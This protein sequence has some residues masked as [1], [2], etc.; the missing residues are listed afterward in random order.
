MGN[1][2][3]NNEDNLYLNGVYLTPETRDISASFVSEYNNETLV[4][5]VFDGM[6]GEALGEEASLIAATAVHEIRHRPGF[7]ENPV[8]HICAAI[9]IANDRI[10][11]KMR[12]TG[13]RRIG[14]TF[15]AVTVKNDMATVYNVG[16]SRVYLYR[17][18]TLTQI[19]VDDTNGQRLLNMGVITPE[20]LEEHPDRHKLTQHLGIY[21]NEMTIEP[22]ISAPIPLKAGDKL[23]ICSDGLT[24][25]VKAT[26]IADVL[27]VS[28]GAVDTT[29]TLVTQAL[30]NGGR[31]NVT[32]MV[33]TALTDPAGATAK[34]AVSSAAVNY[35]PNRSEKRKMTALY[36]VIGLLVA[37]VAVLA[38]MLIMG[39]NDG[40]EVTTEKDEAEALQE[41][42]ADDT[43]A[44]VTDVAASVTD[45]ESEPAD[46]SEPEGEASPEEETAVEPEEEVT[47]GT[48]ESD[49][50]VS[51]GENTEVAETES[52]EAVEP[53][54]ED[55]AET[56]APDEPEIGTF[57][58]LIDIFVTPVEDRIDLYFFDSA[59]FLDTVNNE[60]N[61]DQLRTDPA[62]QLFEPYF[63]LLP[64]ADIILTDDG[65]GECVKVE[66]S[67]G[68]Y[69]IDTSDIEVGSFKKLCM[70][71]VLDNGF[72]QP[73]DV[74]L[75][76]NAD[77]EITVGT[78]NDASAKE[79]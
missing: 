12:E 28:A 4:Y 66:K 14:T 26:M 20:Q 15:A 68:G 2:R 27:S 48:A 69:Y 49:L 7:D 70:S 25:M 56:V 1:I 78:G 43:T 8:E 76:K 10:C 57:D 31:D 13:E 62:L 3:K 45:T 64:V 5:G 33:I 50:P 74:I 53:D 67:D 34:T 79:D 36:A 61:L 19:S 55:T 59:K 16:D 75:V 72:E 39:R 65:T 41:K 63:E 38:V 35:Q 54:T 29:Q 21:K 22:H 40:A 9:E 18:G 23:L 77:G 30:A 73:I 52:E 51:V 37:A 58:T 60:K 46:K 44:A 47:T 11:E 6:G 32:A 17:D 24:D 71:V 42:D